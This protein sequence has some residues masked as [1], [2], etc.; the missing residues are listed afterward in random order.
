MVEAVSHL[1]YGIPIHGYCSLNMEVITLI[2]DAVGG[3]TVTVPEDLKY[4][5]AEMGKGSRSISG[6]DAYTFVQYRD[7]RLPERGGASGQAEAVSA[8]LHH[9]GQ[10]GHARGYDASSYPV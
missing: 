2:N 7:T 3:V 4:G 5:D 6:E 9:A 10:S 1:F 8:G